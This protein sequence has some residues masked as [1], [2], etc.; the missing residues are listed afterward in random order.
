MMRSDI[1][2]KRCCDFTTRALL[3]SA[4]LKRK[5][6]DPEKPFTG[7]ANSYNNIIPNC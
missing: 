5:D 2:K 3:L 1:L 4:G 7:I 6:F